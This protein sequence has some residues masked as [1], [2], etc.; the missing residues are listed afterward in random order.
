M[1]IGEGGKNMKKHF[2]LIEKFKNE[3]KINY[4][5][6][7]LVFPLDPDPQMV[8]EEVKALF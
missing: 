7:L 8:M 4:L 1:D 5:E 3:H 2:D 6:P